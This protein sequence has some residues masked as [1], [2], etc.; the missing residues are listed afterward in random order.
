[1]KSNV[2]HRRGHRRPSSLGFTL[3]ELLVVIGIIALLISVLLPVLNT[4]RR[5]ANETKCLSNMRSIGQA[6]ML[7]QNDNRGAIVPSIAWNGDLD[8]AWAFL[9]V[10]G[11]YLPNPRIMAGSDRTATG[12]SVLVCPS[13]RDQQ[14]SS[15]IPGQTVNTPTSDGYTRRHSKWLM[16]NTDQG[17]NGAGGAAILDIG[18]GINGAVDTGEPRAKNLPMQGLQYG[19]PGRVCH[20]LKKVTQFRKSS[21]TV[22]V[23]DGTEWNHYV[24]TTAHFWRVSGAR[25][26][27]WRMNSGNRQ[28][29]TSGTTNVLFLDGHVSGV[30]RKEL[31]YEAGAA[32]VSQF[33]GTRQE[34][35]NPNIY[36]NSVQ[37]N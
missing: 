33:L 22:L 6:I 23:F 36:W 1:M 8:D 15:S 32:G 31:P 35:L 20:P 25:H 30:P 13:V 11:K 34:M 18:Y 37:S 4:A 21:Q 29:Y 9:L 27:K 19:T 3:V 7:Y 26:G 10:N 28:H 17:D 14:S 16:K 24:T 12:N 5:A 2:H